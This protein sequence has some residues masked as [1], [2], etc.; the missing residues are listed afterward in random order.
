MLDDW[1]CCAVQ[2]PTTQRLKSC[3]EVSAVG[4]TE[5]GVNARGVVPPKLPLPRREIV[6]A[7]AKQ[8]YVSGELVEITQRAFQAADFLAAAQ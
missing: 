2:G 4:I 6:R 1:W 7:G 8:K 3:G 5:L